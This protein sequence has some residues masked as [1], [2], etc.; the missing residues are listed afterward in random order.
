M[1]NKKVWVGAV[2][3]YALLSVLEGVIHGQLLASEYAKMPNL[4]RP[5]EEIMFWL[6]SVTYAIV[7]YFFTL[8]F[9]KGYERKGIAEGVRYGVY[10]GFMMA[11]PMAYFTYATMPITYAL[12]LQWFLY[13][14]LEFILCG[15]VLAWI[16]GMKPKEQAA[17]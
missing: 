14:M 16:F 7:A 9:S 2:V 15:V 5:L 1:K 12:A 13:R 6:L 17:T 10:V 3:V 4:F 11:I 8:I